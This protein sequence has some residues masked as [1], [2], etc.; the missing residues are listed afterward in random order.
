MPDTNSTYGSQI[1][2]SL[3]AIAHLFLHQ[4]ITKSSKDWLD[5]ITGE[6]QGAGTLLDP[7]HTS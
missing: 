3:G 1:Q 2:V 4:M 7:I 6:D 5:V